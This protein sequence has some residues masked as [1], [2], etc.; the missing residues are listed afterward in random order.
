MGGRP[1]WALLSVAVPNEVWNGS[2][3]E[4]FYEGFWE[5]AKRYDVQLIGGDVSRAPEKIVIDSIVLGECAEGKAI[6][7]R[8]AKAGDLLFVTGTLGGSAAGLRLIERGARLPRSRR[9][10]AGRACSAPTTG[11]TPRS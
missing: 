8:G 11:A 3:L 9:T 10:R 5:L 7:R 6:S 1:R 2:F 4:E